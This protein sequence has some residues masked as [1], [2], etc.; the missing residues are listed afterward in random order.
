MTDP[1][2]SPDRRSPSAVKRAADEMDTP[3]IDM[4]NTD[5]Q[6]TARAS[7]RQRRAGS[8]DMA[9]DGRADVQ[10]DASA[11]DVPSIDEQVATVMRLME[12]GLS[13]QAKGYVVSMAWLTR[14]LARSTNG[15]QR[16]VADKTVLEGDIGP[17]DNSDLVLETDPAAGAFSDETGQLFVPLRPG[18][19]M[20]DDCEVLPEPAW[21]LI[22]GIYGVAPHSPV[23]VRYV[24]N[25]NEDG[26]PENLQY[27]LYPPVFTVLKLSPVPPQKDTTPPPVRMLASRHTRYQGWLTS[28]KQQAGIALASKVRVW[29]ILEGLNG[30]AHPSATVTPAV[31]RSASPAPSAAPHAQAGSSLVLDLGTFVALA[32]GSQRE[33]IEQADQTNNEKYN[34]SST[35]NRV[36]LTTD[37][38]IVLEERVAGPAGGE[39][40]S[41]NPKRA[42]RLVS[43][44]TATRGPAVPKLKSKDSAAASSSSLTS[45]PRSS[46]PPNTVTRGRQRKDGRT[47]GVTGLSNLGNTC[48]MSSALQCVRSVEEL[49]QYFLTN[50]YIR[51]LNP[52]NPLSHQGNV[53][54]AYGALLHQLYDE[55]GASSFAPRQFK[56]TIGRY[57]PSFS[58]YGQQD[59]QEFVL[60]LLDGLQED[61]NRIQNKPYIEKPDS[62]DEMR[63]NRDALRRFADECWDIYKARNDSVVTDLFAGMYKSTVICPVCDKVSI[64]F[65]PFNNLTLQLPIE[66]P[67]SHSII[68][69]RLNSRPVKLDLEVDKNAS[70]RS[71]KEHVGRKVNVDADRLIM[72]EVY[73]RKFYKLCDNGASISDFQ[74]SSSDVICMFEVDSVPTSYDANKRPRL[75]SSLFFSRGDTDVPE[76]DSPKSDRILVP[77]FHRCRPEGSRYQQ[78]ALAL[79]PGYVVVNREEAFDYDAV[80]RKV[81]RYVA[82]LTTRDILHEDA[83]DSDT[84]VDG[85]TEKDHPDKK[86]D[87]SSPENKVTATSMPSEDGMVD[88]T[89]HNGNNADKS[90]PNGLQPGTPIPASLRGLFDIKVSRGHEV[91]PLGIDENKDLVSMASRLPRQPDQA[92]TMQQPPADSSSPSSDDELGGPPKPSR[93]Y[94]SNRTLVD[95]ADDSGSQQ[96]GNDESESSDS[97]DVDQPPRQPAQKVPTGPPHPIPLVRAGEA[98]VLD[99]NE[100]AHD[101]LFGGNWRPFGSANNEMRGIFTFDHP[102]PLQDPELDARR[103][104]RQKRKR[105]GVSLDECLD[106]F[107]REEVLSENDAWYCPRCK[108]HRRAT[109]K[110]ELWKTPDIL[111]MHLKRFS[112]HRGF[113]DKIDALVDFP[114]RLDMKGRVEEPDEGKSQEYDLFAVDNHYG[115]LGGGHYTAHAKSFV[116][117]CWYDYNGEHSTTLPY[118]IH[119]NSADSHVS[120]KNNPQG[121]VTPAAYLLFYRRRSTKPLGGPFLARITEAAR[122]PP[123]EADATTSDLSSDS[124]GEDDKS[125]SGSA[126]S[127]GDGGRPAFGSRVGLGSLNGSRASA[128]VG[129]G[130][131]TAA[132]GTPNRQ[133]HGHGRQA[134]AAVGGSRDSQRAAELDSD[135]VLPDYSDGPLA[136]EQSLVGGGVRLPDPNGNDDDQFS[137][138]WAFPA[139][140]G[141]DPDADEGEDDAASN[142][143]VG[144]DRSDD[145]TEGDDRM[146]DVQFNAARG[147]V[148]RE[149]GAG[150]SE[151]EVQESDEEL[152]VAEPQAP[153]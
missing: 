57:G 55:G 34:G 109:K 147:K 115:G 18:L 22:L 114:L 58:G 5:S 80:L 108:A 13:G 39:W 10:A 76:F 72:A 36:G 38:L 8:V 129:V 61:L 106:E 134:E 21:Q 41:N 145:E 97:S 23:I 100:D 118:N 79:A 110:F 125:R 128:A 82:T 113:R 75:G 28:A 73:S 2:Q 136:G 83:D 26:G 104:L 143:A 31:S 14:V 30:S 130:A 48:Y 68:V 63:W 124:E 4:D 1:R 54:K 27:E 77:V 132:A 133:L 74:F 46:P 7:S 116:D 60:F 94:G 70:I 15:P 153:E 62:T 49:T 127:S 84:V 119:T 6:P 45:T 107:G 95:D 40:M 148:E 120:K 91:V 92:A 37:S 25:T 88:V 122:H 47:R 89:M 50:D 69:F 138:S 141:S 151:Q 117:D 16:E 20:G 93:T 65:D 33:Q 9:D 131:G 52:R 12:A 146:G 24:H 87:N 135:E 150:I 140:P 51:D 78:W 142:Q 149:F 85:K 19:Q 67:W 66:S 112:A 56:Q 121:V 86:E 105:H 152:E 123:A 43:E 35:L 90:L 29:R 144:G 103:Q 64:I 42:S 126:T 44:A 32:E 59:S 53:A 98:I 99:W 17:V 102:E 139:A 111:V 81:L 11:A 3:D 96:T 101:G 137:P 71:V